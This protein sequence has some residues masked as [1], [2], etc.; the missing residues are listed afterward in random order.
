V[1]LEPFLPGEY[2][3]P[4][5]TARFGE[6]VTIETE[7]VTVTVQSVLPPEA[8]EAPDIKE[9]APPVSLS[10]GWWWLWVLA[11]ALAAAAALWYF[12]W[13]RRKSAEEA[14]LLPQPHEVA[15]RA[16]RDL[17]AQDLIAKGQAKLLYL[18]LSA[19]LRHYIE[20]RFGLLAPEHTTEEFLYEVRDDARFSDSQKQLLREFL[21]HCDMVKFAEYQP[22]R[23]EIDDTINTCAQF[24]AETKPARDEP[25]VAAV[26]G[27]GG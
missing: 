21:E 9:I 20:G 2:E 15:L 7:P 3:I 17:M 6:D 8:G 12:W 19:I 16:L 13:R 14:E 10:R 18:R 25:A 22:A 1:Q 26:G 27:G 4:A 5:L 24:I 23:E 11:V